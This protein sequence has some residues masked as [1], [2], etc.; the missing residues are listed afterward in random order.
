MPIKPFYNELLMDHLHHP[1]YK[2][3]LPNANLT[4]RGINPS[5]GDQIRLHLRINDV[6]IIQ[7]GS[8]TGEGCAVSQAS[9]D[10]MLGMIIGKDQTEALHLCSLF[11]K[12]IQGTISD[13]E[14]DELG[15]AAVFK[16]ILRMPSRVRCAILSWTTLG[17]TYQKFR[18]ES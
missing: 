11:R 9:A 1:S 14:L 7:D 5:C 2:H 12:M 18:S 13:S 6:G 10:I 4:L 17:E 8:F 16:D 3:E 15:E